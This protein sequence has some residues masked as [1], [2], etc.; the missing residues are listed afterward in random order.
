MALVDDLLVLSIELTL[1]EGLDIDDD[2]ELEELDA[3]GATMVIVGILPDC[4]APELVANSGIAEDAP[5]VV[6]VTTAT[7]HSAWMPSP[8]KNKPTILC[9]STLTPL[10]AVVMAPLV[11]TRPCRQLSEHT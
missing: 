2:V 4:D 6:V 11:V 9:G 7:L 5:L 3:M 1:L 10:H 8:F